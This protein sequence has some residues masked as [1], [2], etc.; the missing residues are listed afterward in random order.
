MDELDTD[1][2][3]LNEDQDKIYDL[4]LN[5][6][7]LNKTKIGNYMFFIDGPG[8]EFNYLNLFAFILINFINLKRIRHR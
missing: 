6:I 4:I 7:I 8:A 2:K 3:R 5:A 1:V